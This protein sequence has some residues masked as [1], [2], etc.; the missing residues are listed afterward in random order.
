VYWKIQR[1]LTGWLIIWIWAWVSKTFVGSEKMKQLGATHNLIVCQKSQIDYWIDHIKTF[2]P[3][4]EVLDLT[5]RKNIPKFL[6]ITDFFKHVKYMVGI[7]NY[8]L[9]WHRPELSDITNMSLI[10]DESSLIQNEKAKRTKFILK[11]KPDNVI[12]L[13]GTPTSGKYENLWSQ[14]KLLGWNI[15]KS[16]YWSQ[17]INTVLMDIGGCKFKMVDKRHPYKNVER[18]KTKLREHGAV[19]MKTEEVIQLPEQNFIEIKVNTPSAYKKFMA[20]GITT[21]DGIQLIGDTAL[22]KRLYARQIVSQYNKNKLDAV[23]DLL[24][25]TSD[26]III[27]Y[28][29]NDELYQL[30]KLCAELKRPVS[31]VNGTVKDIANFSKYDHAVLLGQYQ[32]ASMGLN[33]QQANKIIY[34]SLPERSELFEQSKKRIHRI[35]QAKPCFYYILIAKNSVD[36]MILNA[37][38]RKQD[39]TDELFREGCE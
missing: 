8:D 32:A 3:E 2:Y 39:F 16:L 5:C 4:Y 35:G 14:C 12:L 37:L 38:K 33:L 31:I 19:F 34:F 9:I 28:N 13:S 1:I 24:E 17:F 22:T 20:D 6:H 10:L 26:R 23:R 30:R 25:S 27:F 7:I 18:L 21:V 29:F 15:T 36:G 11:L